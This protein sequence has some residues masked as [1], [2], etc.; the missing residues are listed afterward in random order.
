MKTTEQNHE[1]QLKELQRTLEVIQRDQP[2]K[3]LQAIACRKVVD[4]VA[5]RLQRTA[6]AGKVE[7]IH[8]NKIIQPRILSLQ[9]LYRW[10]TQWYSQEPV[11]IQEVQ[12]HYKRV[13]QQLTDFHAEHRELVRYCRSGE[14]HLDEIYFAAPYQTSVLPYDSPIYQWATYLAYQQLHSRISQG[15]AQHR[16]TEQN[17]QG[18]TWTASK[19]NLIELLYALHTTGVVNE[20]KSDLKQMAEAF[21][22]WFHVS[23]GNYYRVFQDIRLRK[24][25]QTVFL[26]QLKEKFLQR[27][28]ELE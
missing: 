20:G 28:H 23:L 14:T 8:F 11:D 26:D 6:P 16:S 22:Q 25:N 4:E 19:T 9:I 3:L 17:E 5:Q 27:V 13:L 12:G 7:Q 1:Q 10:L 15:I 18:L 2:D 24:I 21:E